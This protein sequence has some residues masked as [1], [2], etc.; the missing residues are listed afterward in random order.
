MKS[1][2]CKNQKGAAMIIVLCVMMVILV[3]C[4][5]VLLSTSMIL[6]NANHAF[7]KEQCRIWAVSL[8]EQL[9][10]ALL[11]P[12]FETADEEA[13][14]NDQTLWFYVKSSL[15]DGS[16]PYLDDAEIGHDADFA[17]RHFSLAAD[18]APEGVAAAVAE[19]DISAYWLR[20]EADSFEDIS[21]HV[22]VSATVNGQSCTISSEYALSLLEIGA[23]D[24]TQPSYEQWSWILLWRE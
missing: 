3:L 5:S 10:Q 12:A 14:A 6:A 17:L 24:E 20:T 18:D 7:A 21:L 22:E 19:M 4:V 23:D 8:S 9:D 13:A 2:L 1:A 16:W 11:T 15:Q